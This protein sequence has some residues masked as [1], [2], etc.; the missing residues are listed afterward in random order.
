MAS[1]R[2][3]KGRTWNVEV[4]AAAIKRVK[5]ETGL[6]LPHLIDLSGEDAKKVLSDPIALFECLCS[7]L[8]PQLEQRGV[9]EE[10]FGEALDEASCVAAAEALLEAVIFFTRPQTR[11]VLQ[12][13]WAKVREHGRSLEQKQIALAQQRV[14]SSEFDRALEQ[15]AENFVRSVSGEPS[16]SSPELPASTPHS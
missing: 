1:F 3:M 9:S 4:H 15:A 13:A 11:Q 7:L 5:A 2:D 12:R 6:F 8:R 10:E 14:E 16:I